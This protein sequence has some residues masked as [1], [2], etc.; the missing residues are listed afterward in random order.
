[1]AFLSPPS[2]SLIALSLRRALR[3]ARP[4]APPRR[5][6]ASGAAEPAASATTHFGAATVAS[7]DKARLVAGVFEK[8]AASYDDM[9]DLM[10][11]GL[12]RLWKDEFVR[13][14]GPLASDAP[15]P[16]GAGAGAGSAAA[17]APTVLLDVAGGTG[18]VA[19]R[20][21]E[22]LRASL[23][24]PPPAGAEGA[25]PPTVIV[26]DINPAMLRVGEQR[27]RARGY[28]GGGGIGS[29]AAAGGAPGGSGGVQPVL[30]WQQ[31]DAERLDFLADASVDL[32]T[33]AFGI[34]NVTRVDAALR[35]AHRVLRPGGRFMCLEFSRVTQPLLA[36]LYDAYSDAAI[37]RMGELVAGDR[38]SYQYLVESIRRFPDQEAFADMIEEAGFRN[39]TYRNLT[40]GVCAVHSGFK[41]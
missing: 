33:I 22:G 1:M 13:L 9:N 14:A 12:H 38:A 24:R 6:L 15:P 27:A 30:R 21:F 23:V 10:S 39:V 7:A 17:Y 37:P 20:L 41:W 36:R 11:A 18:D 16:A 28:G 26:C 5:G 19:F 34:R 29:G 3:A 32:Y 31:G 8:V 25:A 4:A 35:E 2:R 40:Y